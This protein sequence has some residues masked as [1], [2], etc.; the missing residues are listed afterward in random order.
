MS[1]PRKWQILQVLAERL[2]QIKTVHGYHTDAGN[3]VCLEARQIVD[4]D[5]PTITVYAGPAALPDNAGSKG[6]REFTV[7]IETAVPVSLE[8]AQQQLLLMMEDIET[9][10]DA[11]LQQPMALPLRF[12]EDTILDRPD[13]LPVM[14]CQQLFVTRYRR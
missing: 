11:Y 13:G 12:V 3:S 9:A 4:G 6:E 5:C 10:L 2:R 14:A 8:S 1:E 7:I